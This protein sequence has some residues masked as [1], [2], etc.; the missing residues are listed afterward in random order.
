MV[1]GVD[2]A[3][4]GYSILNTGGDYARLVRVTAGMCRSVTESRPV[5][6][7]KGMMPQLGCAFL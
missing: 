4:P 5:Q 2:L 7:A 6:E 1:L 3:R